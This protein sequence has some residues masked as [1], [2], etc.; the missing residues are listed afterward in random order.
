MEKEKKVLNLG[1]IISL[2]SI[3]SCIFPGMQASTATRRPTD[4]QGK[5]QRSLYHS[6]MTTLIKAISSRTVYPLCDTEAFFFSLC[7]LRWNQKSV[8]VQFSATCWF[9]FFV[10]AL[11]KVLSFCLKHLICIL[12]CSVKEG[13][14]WKERRQHWQVRKRREMSRKDEEWSTL[15]FCPLKLLHKKHYL[16][17]WLS[18]F[19]PFTIM[20]E[21]PIPEMQPLGDKERKREPS[22]MLTLPP[23]SLSS[24]TENC[25]PSIVK[26]L[27]IP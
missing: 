10:S 25:S 17:L 4:C 6:S 5:G 8:F 15:T 19:F 3:S 20:E 16:L 23:C 7:V 26:D 14:D 18:S 22:L 24:W 9:S 11:N 2:S 1:D 13:R 21:L 12:W 27:L